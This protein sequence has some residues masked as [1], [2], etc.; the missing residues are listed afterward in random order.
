[1]ETVSAGENISLP[2]QKRLAAYTAAL[3]CWDRSI[4]FSQLADVKAD[5]FGGAGGF[6]HFLTERVDLFAVVFEGGADFGF[7]VV[8]YDKVREVR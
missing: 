7:E 2:R 5:V 6:V 1:M 4:P 3:R 8:D